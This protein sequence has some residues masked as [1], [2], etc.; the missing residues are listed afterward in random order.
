MSETRRRD[1]LRWLGAGSVGLSLPACAPSKP[2]TTTTTPEP[3]AAAPAT[4]VVPARR[5][6]SVA[7]LVVPKLDTVRVGLI[8]LGRR[9]SGHVIHM[10]NLEGVEVTALCDLR[11]EPLAR[12]Q[13]EVVA[14]GR[15]EPA[16]YGG[17]EDAYLELLK[18][19][20]V[21]VV[22]ISTPWRFHAPMAID[23]MRAGKH[24]LLEVPAA[25]SVQEC[26]DLVD[27]AEQTQL[28]CMMLENVCYGRDELMVLNMV[29]QGV[30]G[31]LLHGEAAYIHELRFQMHDLTEGTG[32]WRTGWHAERNGNLYPTHGLGPISQYMGIN[33]GDRF[34]YLSSFSSPARGRQRYAEA[35]F[36]PENQ[37]NQ[38]RY[39]CGDINTT[40]IKTNGGRTIMVQHDTTTPR[41]YS[42]HNLIQGTKGVFGGFPN[43][44]AI[45]RPEEGK[46]ASYHRWDGN[47]EP[48]YQQYDHPLWTRMGTEAER[49]GGHGGMD[50]LMFW[51]TISCLRNGEPL[52]QDV[53]DAAAWSVLVPL[54]AESVANRSR[55]VDVP[56]FTRGEFVD[57]TPLPVVR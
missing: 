35:N 25:L 11:P 45:E 55:S 8:G 40:V 48:W 23:A 24:V 39:I 43:R 21:D 29:R 54:T 42:R 7:G 12:S 6:K 27:T 26:W 53:Y 14:R 3:A 1:F 30:F 10:C 22:I 50:F 19:D 13:R 52:D 9:G 51:R 56:D 17:S 5:G 33:R 2:S 16:T 36:P 37:R 34:D 28:N 18:R 38:V 31:E 32:F 20:D 47:M 57:R 46:D 49:N 41:P 4:P 44:I 15:P